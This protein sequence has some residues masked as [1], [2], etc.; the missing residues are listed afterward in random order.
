MHILLI[1]SC[2]GF[3]YRDISKV[4]GDDLEKSIDLTPLTDENREKH[5]IGSITETWDKSYDT[6]SKLLLEITA[7]KV[8]VNYKTY[9]NTF[10]ACLKSS[11]TLELVSF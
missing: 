5:G 6:R 11:V 2:A 4:A 7:K 8:S 1:L 9:L 3:F 10:N